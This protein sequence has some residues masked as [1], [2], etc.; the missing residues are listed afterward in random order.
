MAKKTA[1]AKGVTVMYTGFKPIL[2]TVGGIEWSEANNYT[3]VV[4]DPALVEDLLTDGGFVLVVTGDEPDPE[5]G[6]PFVRITET[7]AD[8]T[9]A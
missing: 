8:E 2:R 3:A 4:E 5:G 6:V 7:V 9:E 1:P